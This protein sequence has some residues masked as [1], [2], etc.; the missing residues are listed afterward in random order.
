MKV[1]LQLIQSTSMQETSS[2]DHSQKV[3]MQLQEPHIT[4]FGMRER[5]LMARF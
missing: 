5:F 3:K 1:H 4:H 2:K